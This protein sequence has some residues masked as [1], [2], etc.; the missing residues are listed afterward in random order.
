MERDFDIETYDQGDTTV[1]LGDEEARVIGCLVEKA[2]TTPDQ[3]PMTLNG[4]TLACNQKS[5]RDPVV[6]LAEALVER[7]L[8]DLTDA[9]IAR[10]VH[11]PGDRVVK[12][13]HALDEV[14]GVDDRE[15]ALLAVM[16]LRG[17]QTPGELRQRTQRYVEFP[18]LVELDRTLDTLVSRG[19]VRQLARRPGQKESRYVE[20]VSLRGK[21]TEDDAGPVVFASA[22]DPT[23]PSP[24]APPSPPADTTHEGDAAL[25]AEVDELRR[26]FERLL[27]QLGVDDV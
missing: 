3:Y 14:L 16:L 8:R 19:L 2:M 13:K 6:D 10:M 18:D 12:Y 1:S 22:A 5:N 4:V 17:P 24:Q 11:R 15:L 26:R 23:P 25:R 20:Q 27:D 9:G 21:A 7:T